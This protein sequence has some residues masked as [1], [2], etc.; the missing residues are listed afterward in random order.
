MSPHKHLTL[1]CRDCGE[2]HLLYTAYCGGLAAELL[3][4]LGRRAKYCSC[5]GVSGAPVPNLKL[6]TL[7][8][9]AASLRVQEPSRA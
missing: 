3:A 2:Q 5:V 4:F 8:E 7:V 6:T 1:E 9:R